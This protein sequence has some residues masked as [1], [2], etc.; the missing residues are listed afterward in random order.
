MLDTTDPKANR[1]LLADFLETLDPAQFDM[2][3]WGDEPEARE[4][5]TAMC[6]AGWA[7]HIFAGPADADTEQFAAEV[8][9]LG[10]M[11]AFNLFYDIDIL[12]PREAATRLRA[13]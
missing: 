1:E 10:G 12:T 4:C 11:Q 5:G 3:Y 2:G 13:L 8:L 6:I 7:K 9:G